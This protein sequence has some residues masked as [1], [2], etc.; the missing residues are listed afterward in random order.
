MQS[1]YGLCCGGRAGTW[2]DVRQSLGASW[3]ADLSGRYLMIRQK[4]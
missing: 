4:K 3:E 1:E 2:V